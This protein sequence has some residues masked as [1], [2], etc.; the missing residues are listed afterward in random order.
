MRACTESWSA[1]WSRDGRVLLAHRSPN[2]RAY[3]DT[4]DLSGGVIED[5]ESE[6]GALA[7]ELHEE[8][9]HDDIRWFGLEEVPPLAHELVRQTL[10]SAALS[11]RA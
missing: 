1:R 11:R 9:E 8:Q 7:R 6:L 3:P 4:W 10:V 2:K 5:G